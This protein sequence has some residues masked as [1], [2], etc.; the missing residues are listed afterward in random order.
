MSSSGGRDELNASVIAEWLVNKLMDGPAAVGVQPRMY[1]YVKG[2][3]GIKVISDPDE[4]T[5]AP[6]VLIDGGRDARPSRPRKLTAVPRLTNLLSEVAPNEESMWQTA[7]VQYISTPKVCSRTGQRVRAYK[8]GTAGL[9]VNWHGI[10]KM[11]GILTAGHV[12]RSRS[13]ATV[14]NSRGTVVAAIDFLNSGNVPKADVAVIGLS[15]SV[16]C[17]FNQIG[18]VDLNEK[19]VIISTKKLKGTNV[20]SDLCGRIYMESEHGT[21]GGVY[22]AKPAV[23]VNGDSGA[24]VINSASEVIGHVIATS[25]NDFDYIQEINY[26]L[27]AIRSSNTRLSGLQFG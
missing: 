7:M 15:G 23:A 13:T 16:D 18:R 25:G 17:S 9:K 22:L 27:Q 19:V 21:P 6:F 1:P 20:R 4:G 8:T 10:E 11:E 26:Q 12:V 24:V 5:I 2:V 14:G 3:C